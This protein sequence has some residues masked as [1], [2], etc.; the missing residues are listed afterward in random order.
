MSL[1]LP[2]TSHIPIFKPQLTQCQETQEES[3]FVPQELLQFCPS[4]P[5]QCGSI[6]P[7]ILQLFFQSKTHSFSFF[8]GSL[9]VREMRTSSEDFGREGAILDPF[10]VRSLNA[11]G[12]R[13]SFFTGQLRDREIRTS[14]EDFGRDD[15]ILDL[16]AVCLLNA[17]G[18]RTSVFFFSSSFSSLLPIF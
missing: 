16:F 18:Q 15:V 9:Q 1:M 11:N 2:T 8:T 13:T 3:V 5:P 14:S 4:R 10:A 6:Q 7:F 17:N 12:Q